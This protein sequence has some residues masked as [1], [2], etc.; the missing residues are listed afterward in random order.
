MQKFLK[1]FLI[2]E[3]E[4]TDIPALQ[5]T[6]NGNTLHAWSSFCCFLRKKS[7]LPGFGAYYSSSKTIHQVRGDAVWCTSFS[8][9]VRHLLLALSLVLLILASWDETDKVT[10]LEVVS[11]NL[12]I[13]FAWQQRPVGLILGDAVRMPLPW[14]ID[15]GSQ[16]MYQSGSQ[17]QGGKTMPS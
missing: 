4:D 17:W 11:I 2:R 16:F 3:L 14:I 8:S 10:S 5:P 13:V 12:P 1:F 9:Q 6:K 15:I 7:V